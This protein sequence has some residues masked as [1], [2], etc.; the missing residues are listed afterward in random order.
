[1]EKRKLTFYLGICMVLSVIVFWELSVFISNAGKSIALPQECLSQAD[2]YKKWSCF[3]PYFEAVTQRVSTG[4]AMAEAKSLEKSGVVSDCHLFSHVIGVASVEKYNF[5]MGQAF[6]SCV[7]GCSDGCFHGVMERYVRY[8]SDPND[9][10]SKVQNMCDSVGTEWIRKRQCIHGIGHGLIAHNFLPIQDALKACESL[11]LDWRRHCVGGLTM[12]Y[13]D[14]YLN[15]NLQESDLKKAL[16]GICAPFEST[17]PSYKVN[18]CV[19]QVSL[20][21]MYY[22]G[23]DVERSRKLCEELGNQEYVRTCKNDINEV[24][25]IETPANIDIEQ[26]LEHLK[27]F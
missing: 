13:V 5:D 15:R 12:E 8:A 10:A 7:F 14:Q 17:D 9:V 3:E 16:P 1:M 27:V 18:S 22:T 25:L 26:F 21:L 2:G 23:H 11:D 20:G 6:S 24:V 4:A 19:F